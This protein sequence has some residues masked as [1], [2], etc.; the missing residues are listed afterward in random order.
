MV[1]KPLSEV[2]DALVLGERAAAG[3]ALKHN[4]QNILPHAVSVAF[5]QFRDHRDFAADAGDESPVV[6]FIRTRNEKPS[7]RTRQ[8]HAGGT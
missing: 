2:C 3:G 4:N 6:V 5:L 7:R 8:V 1:V